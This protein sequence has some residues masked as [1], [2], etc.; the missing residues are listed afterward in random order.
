M[1][2]FIDIN[3]TGISSLS[4]PVRAEA[5]SVKRPRPPS[6]ARIRQVLGKDQRP[7]GS[8]WAIRRRTP[9]G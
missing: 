5:I 8:R 4:R 3:L 9:P 7:G 1:A 6:R 2:T